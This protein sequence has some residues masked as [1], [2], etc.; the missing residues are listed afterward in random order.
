MDSLINNVMFETRDLHLRQGGGRRIVGRSG[1]LSFV[2]DVE[3]GTAVSVASFVAAEEAFVGPR[4]VG[5]SLRVS[6]AEA[7]VLHPSCRSRG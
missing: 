6:A 4:H 5:T 3:V 7:R 2:W 1:L